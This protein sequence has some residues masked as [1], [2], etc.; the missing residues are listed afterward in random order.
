MLKKL[1]KMVPV[2]AVFLFVLMWI[3]VIPTTAQTPAPDSIVVTLDTDA[4][5][6]GKT[7]EIIVT[8]TVEN[9]NDFAVSD[10]KIDMESLLPRSYEIKSITKG[11]VAS[12]GK[13]SKLE[14]NETVVFE[15]TLSPVVLDPMVFISGEVESEVN[16]SALD[17]NTEITNGTTYSGYWDDTHQQRVWLLNVSD[18]EAIDISGYGSIEFDLYLPQPYPDSRLTLGFDTPKGTSQYDRSNI[19]FIDLDWQGW[20][21]FSVPLYNAS[22]DKQTGDFTQICRIFLTGIGWGYTG[23]PE[24]E[25]YIG[26]VWLDPGSGEDWSG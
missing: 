2:L 21:H 17:P 26:K 12:D 20:K 6:Y 5:K 1:N 25:A 22:F 3:A 24:V 4:E 13:V 7:D 15:V 16:T 19:K 9:T 8:V 14:A 23:N 11:G 18:A 10:V